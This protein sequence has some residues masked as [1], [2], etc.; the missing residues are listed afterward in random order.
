VCD[1]GLAVEVGERGGVLS[2][3]VNSQL[4]TRVME[5]SRRELC[6]RLKSNLPCDRPWRRR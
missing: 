6:I 3:F 1:S 2:W 4:R 5:V